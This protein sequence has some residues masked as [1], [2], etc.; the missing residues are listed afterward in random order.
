M[1]S[2]PRKGGE[3]ILG[4]FPAQIELRQFVTGH[5][6]TGQI[7]ATAWNGEK[8]KSEKNIRKN[9]SK[10]SERMNTVQVN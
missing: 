9:K 5:L 1:V 6:N 2:S 4:A 10:N 8:I 7:Q 3:A